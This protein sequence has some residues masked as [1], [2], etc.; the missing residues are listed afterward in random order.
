[1]TVQETKI[2]I[3]E[4]EGSLCA[5]DFSSKVVDVLGKSLNRE[6]MMTMLYSKISELK[7]EKVTD[8]GISLGDQP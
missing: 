2:A 4:I 8:D 5:K 6:D 7:G 3:M 1:M